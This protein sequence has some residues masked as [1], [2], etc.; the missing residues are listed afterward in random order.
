M[1]A[2]ELITAHQQLKEQKAALKREYEKSVEDIDTTLEK[3]TSA[4]N[5]IMRDQGVQNI[6]GED[7][8]A[9]YGLK[10]SASVANWDLF[11]SWALAN[12]RTD[13]LGHHCSKDAIIAY[14]EENDDA[15]PPGINW[16]AEKELRIRRA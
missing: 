10:T 5:K 7:G 6:K 11:L 13:L 9:Y 15:L 1:N 2:N 4:L 16:Y 12:D 3:I 14:K 8:L